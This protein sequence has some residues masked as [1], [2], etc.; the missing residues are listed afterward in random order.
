MSNSPPRKRRPPLSVRFNDQ[1]L[2]LLRQKAGDM[3]LSSY[4]KMAGL[5]NDAPVMRRRSKP[6]LDQQILATILA[7]LGQSRISNNLNQLAKAVHSGS[8]PVNEETDRD[9]VQACQDVSLIRKGLLMALGVETDLNE[10]GLKLTFNSAAYA[11]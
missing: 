5:G 3:P 11:P 8:L 7:A 10:A 4:L 6:S 2:D 9:L 1:E